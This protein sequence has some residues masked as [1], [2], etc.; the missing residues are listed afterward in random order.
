MYEQNLHENVKLKKCKILTK[1]KKTEDSVSYT[2][3]FRL[4]LKFFVQNW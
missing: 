2:V 1:K 3:V 4:I